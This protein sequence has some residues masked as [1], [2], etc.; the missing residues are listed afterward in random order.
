L[1]KHFL[2]G[3]RDE[4][5]RG[6]EN[7]VSEPNLLLGLVEL[8]ELLRGVLC[9]HQSDDAVQKIVVADLLVNEEALR[10][11][12]R[13]GQARRLDDDALEFELAGVASLP[14]LPQDEAEVAARGAA[15]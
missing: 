13:I 2:L 6:H 7:P 11:R 8:V 9:V 15:Y 12:P 3:I 14:D 4:C 5:G 10:D 1:T